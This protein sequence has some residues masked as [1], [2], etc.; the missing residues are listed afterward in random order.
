MAN[1]HF[2]DNGAP[3]VSTDKIYMLEF[4]TLEGVK[5]FTDLMTISDALKI[6]NNLK[7]GRETVQCEVFKVE[8]DVKSSFQQFKANVIEVDGKKMI[9]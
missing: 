1:E 2:W 7:A 3:T 8:G 9:I 6:F 5:R 4:E